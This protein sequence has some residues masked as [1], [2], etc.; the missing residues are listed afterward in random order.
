MSDFH[1]VMVLCLAGATAAGC[2]PRAVTLDEPSGTMTTADQVAYTTTTPKSTSVESGDVSG[3]LS[4]E[5]WLAAAERDDVG[6][7]DSWEI[8]EELSGAEQAERKEVL[9]LGIPHLALCTRVVGFGEYDEWGNR[10][11]EETYTFIAHAGQPV[12]IYA[13]MEGVSSRLEESSHWESITSQHLVI[14]S[15]RDGLPIWEEPW[16]TASDRSRVRRRSY[17]TTQV[18]ELPSALS[19]GKY[20]LTLRVRDDKTGEEAERSIWFTMAS[21]RRK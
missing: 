7:D 13:E 2:G 4:T 9:N 10:T 17:F 18:V 1:H 11:G 20:R 12:I 15:E 5:D 3:P 14:H 19:A 21:A 16:Q 6:T 8:F